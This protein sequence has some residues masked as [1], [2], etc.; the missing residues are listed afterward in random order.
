MTL[1]LSVTEKYV[2][3]EINAEKSLYMFMSQQNA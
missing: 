3:L 1:A 2:G